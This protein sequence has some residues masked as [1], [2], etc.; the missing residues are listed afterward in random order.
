MEKRNIV[1]FE[2]PAKDR[3][4]SAQFF[5]NVFGWSFQ[6]AQQPAP[7]T[8]IETGNI[9]GGLPDMQDFYQPGH[10]ILYVDSDDI[11]ADL[12]HIEAYGGKA[13]SSPFP[14]G[15]FGEMAFFADPTGN[16][17]AL[18]RELKPDGETP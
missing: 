1:H 15:D 5:Q 10:V 17:L 8:L 12:K 6:H 3:E 11:Q 7:Y 4:A 9:G 13:L 2:I 16:R 14:V 18:W